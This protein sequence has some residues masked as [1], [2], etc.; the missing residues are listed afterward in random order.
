MS[1]SG[2]GRAASSE[3]HLFREQ[4][5][6]ILASSD[7]S[8]SRHLSDFLSYSTECGLSGRTHLDQVEIAAKVLGRP[9]FNPIEDA[10]VRKLATHV[11]QR[12][13][14]YYAGTGEKDEVRVI[15][16]VRSYIPRFERVPRPVASAGEPR[17]GKRRYAILFA[18]TASA[19]VL[20]L[21]FRPSPQGAHDGLEILTAR[22]DIVGTINDALPGAI[23]LGPALQEE[24]EVTVR[25]KFTAER[26]AQQAGILIWQDADNFVRF[27]RKFTGRNLLEFDLEKNGTLQATP[28][29]HTYE[30]D[31]Q[32]GKPLWLSVRRAGSLF[33]AFVSRDG[34]SWVAAGPALRFE[35]SGLRSG[36]Y[37]F[38]GRRDAPTA[39]AVFDHFS[40]GPTFAHWDD[41]ASLARYGFT[42]SSNCTGG[43]DAWGLRDQALVVAPPLGSARCSAVLRRTVEGTEWQF[44]TRLDFLPTAEVGAGIFVRGGKSRLRLV[45]NELNGAAI[46]WIHEGVNVAGR[47]DFSGSPAI[48]LRLSARQGL[49]RAGFSRN[50]RDYQEFPAVSIESVGAPIQ[51]G[52]GALLNDV[53]PAQPYTPPLFT[54]FRQEDLFLKPYK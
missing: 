28:L 15:L 10:T 19:V 35:S 1:E 40:V 46:S 51:I 48:Y 53:A 38:N 9:D 12:L 42:F 47:K 24:D 20:L 5:A 17:S 33:A 32:D 50:D 30:P 21:W 16:P 39:S 29:S 23:R 34:L 52:I 4:L 7:F 14:Q 22:G 43:E 31:G 44:K 2:Q 36:L 11:R 13:E 3:E 26:E 25:L 41:K 8:S 27:G 49:L 37:A 54:F 18:A 6:R 45:R